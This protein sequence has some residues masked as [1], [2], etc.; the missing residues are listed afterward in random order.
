MTRLTKR[1]TTLFLILA[2]MIVAVP[3]L[4]SAASPFK[5]VKKT[6][7]AYSSIE[8]AYK[9]GITTG[10]T[11][12]P[13]SKVTE[14]QF[15]D[16][17]IR[18]DCLAADSVKA[19]TASNYRYLKS[20]N[21]PVN[22]VSNMK[23]RDLPITKGQVARIAAAYRGVDV[24]ETRA[25]QYMYVNDLANGA[26]GKN[27]YKDYGA[28]LSMTRADAVV[29]LQ[30]LSNSGDCEMIGLSKRATGSD[31]KT[32]T[33]PAGFLGTGTV[34]FKPPTAGKQ[35]TVVTQPTVPPVSNATVD[36]DVD[37]S[38]LI[39]NG[40][41]STFVTVSL[42]GCTNGGTIDYSDSMSFSV[43]SA[44][45]A[46]IESGQTY[47]P[48]KY[49]LKEAIASAEAAEA[50]LVAA[51]N[52]VDLAN[53]NLKYWQSVL[54]KPIGPIGG[55]I[56]GTIQDVLQAQEDLIEA[57]RLATIAENQ[58]VAARAYLA[59]A[60][61][62]ENNRP[63][64][65]SLANMTDGPDMIVKV[66]AP[67]SSQYRMD[68][69]TFQ[70]NQSNIDCDNRPITVHLGYAPQAELRLEVI[71]GKTAFNGTLPANGATATLK[72]TVVAPGGQ[73]IEGYT[74]RVRFRSTHGTTLSN[75]YVSFV[76]GVAST[77][78]ISPNTTYSI[79][80]EISAEF[81]VVDPTYRDVLSS[82]ANTTHYLQ[83]LYE[84]TLRADTT[85][86]STVPEIAFIID[87]SGSMRSSD[88]SYA[89]VTKSRELM[90]ALN[91]PK[92]VAAQF[93][94]SGRLLHPVAD[95][96]AIVEPTLI[97]VGQSGGTNIL[98]GLKTAFGKF[99]T[100]NSPKV[101]I[102]LTDGKSNATQT[103][104]IIAEAKQRNIKIYTIGLGN[105][106]QLNEALLQQI[107]KDT[108]GH[109]YHVAQSSELGVA[110]QNILSAITCDIPAGP[111]CALS[112]Q[113]FTSPTLETIGKDFFMNTYVNNNCGQITRVV[114]RFNSSE[115]NIDYELANRNAAQGYFALQKGTHEIHNFHLLQEGL[116]LAYNAKGELVGEKRVWMVRR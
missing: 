34:T 86:S 60:Q 29:F 115:G 28:N 112:S 24:S 43:K 2:M 71:P 25:V 107:A 79:M 30:R 40:V 97:K 81:D 105:K 39:A 16:M 44:L 19:S 7:P 51:K 49:D 82:V 98:S 5:D 95:T 104:S 94:T 59:A 106:K 33:L 23:A 100:G 88:P 99:T 87:S 32:I 10:S 55:N 26:T 38:T 96:A 58:A 68:T 69:L 64:G 20:K 50:S 21:I 76:N 108:G 27:D 6:H 3:I 103:L 56:V 66:T 14:A 12:A 35:P 31:D 36:I 116:F 74:G 111:A 93:N 11:F 110:Y 91:V 53:V 78:I 42:K 15:V 80:D 57:Q 89:R 18:L 92:N 114:L 8:W 37:K 9:E 65:T 109:Y 102:L 75:E 77:T 22:G 45:G 63:S 67:E 85:C 46:K 52:K 47:I 72:A 13:D 1:A 101:A 17:L 62:E 48:L 83:V 61:A 90:L 41:D 73:T 70:L 4:V 54:N 84:P 113:L